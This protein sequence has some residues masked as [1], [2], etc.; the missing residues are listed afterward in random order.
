MPLRAAHTL[1]AVWLP[2]RHQI[3]ALN[4]V[5]PSRG[6]A[7]SRLKAAR[8]RFSRPSQAQAVPASSHSPVSGS[9]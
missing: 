8:M 6:A 3:R 5:P 4:T 9:T 7:G 2:V 1:P